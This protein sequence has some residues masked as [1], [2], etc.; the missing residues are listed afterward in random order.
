M[1]DEISNVIW[2]FFFRPSTIAFILLPLMVIFA[3]ALI[4]YFIQRNTYMNSEYYTLTQTSFNTLRRDKGLTGEY[5]ICKYL[6]S[7]EGKKRFLINCYIPKDNNTTTEIDIILLHSSGIYVFESKNYSGWI[8]GSESQQ[9]WTQTFQSRKKERFY[10]PIMQNNTHIKWL[11]RLLPEFDISVFHSVIVFSERCE[12]KKIDVTS[13]RH[14]VIK[15]NYLL[16]TVNETAK[17]QMLTD[18]NIEKVYQKLIPFTQ[19]SEQVKQAHIESIS[20][21][22]RKVH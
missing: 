11:M 2:Q 7:L 14:S 22:G 4:A 17:Q 15:R 3:I 18:D 20:R 5:L 1:M 8:F 9:Q 21:Q 13:N 6:S 10:N 12:L 19:V 16:R